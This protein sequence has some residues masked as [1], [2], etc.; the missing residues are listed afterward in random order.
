MPGKNRSMGKK[1]AKKM[2][3][4]PSNAKGVNKAMGRF[5]KMLAAKKKA[6]RK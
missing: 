4:R 3:K 1:T 2:K 5:D 6:R